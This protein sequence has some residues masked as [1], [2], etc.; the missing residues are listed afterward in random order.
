MTA[1]VF[2][3]EVVIECVKKYQSIAPLEYHGVARLDCHELPVWIAMELPL[4]IAMELPLWITTELPLWIAM[5][6]LW[7]RYIVSFW[8]FVAAVVRLP[9]SS[10]NSTAWTSRKPAVSME[11]GRRCGWG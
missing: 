7:K 8:S 1:T 2:L 10:I 9:I 4:W 6:I 11:M 3:V 5:E